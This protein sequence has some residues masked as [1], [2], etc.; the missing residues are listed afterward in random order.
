MSNPEQEGREAFAQKKPKDS[1]PYNG[2]KKELEWKLGYAK[3]EYEEVK[4]EHQGVLESMGW[5]SEPYTG[6][7]DIIN[8][9]QESIQQYQNDLLG[10]RNLS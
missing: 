1:C 9:L 3:Q 10:S 8:N 6:L 5:K 7:E 4:E 2:G